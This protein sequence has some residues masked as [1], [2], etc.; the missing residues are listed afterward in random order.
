MCKAGVRSGANSWRVCEPG[1]RC[2]SPGP[3]TRQRGR[4]F[5][6]PEILITQRPAEADESGSTRT[7]GR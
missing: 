7:L 1:E 6:H 4:T 5:V 3:R 2:G